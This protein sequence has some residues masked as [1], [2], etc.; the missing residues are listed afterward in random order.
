MSEPITFDVIGVP[1]PQGSKSAFVRGGRAVIVDGSSKTGRDKHAA[2]RADVT[3]AARIAARGRTFEGPVAVEIVF[4]LALPASDPY[5]TMHT[6]SPDLD[7]LVR[8]VLDSLTNSGLI[9]DDSLVWN[10]SACKVYARYPWPT[11][12]E[13]SVT[14]N[15]EAEEASRRALKES[16]AAE[17]KS[18]RA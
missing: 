2:W 13:I 9:R 12:A 6:T 18:K 14:D 15:T 4:R 7:K 11:G 5:R 8:S 16:A 1:A 17:R 3:Q 10:I